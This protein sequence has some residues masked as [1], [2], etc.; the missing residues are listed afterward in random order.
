MEVRRARAEDVEGIAQVCIEGC[1]D[2]YA[3]IRSRE[4]IER[5]NRIFYNHERITSELQ[6]ED[7]WDGYIVAVD[8]EEVVGAIGGGMISEKESEVYV[9]YLD[10][11]RRREGIG[12]KL[13]EFL[14]GIHLEKGAKR[15]WVSVQKGNQKGLPFYEAKG[16]QYQ[17]ERPA[18]SNVEGENY[19]SFRMSREIGKGDA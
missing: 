12:S 5:N 10:P 1:W 11:G 9:L 19:L 17:S 4:N 2:T 8:N 3:G 14:T 6:E 18:Y 16:F 15:Q 13:L 7:G